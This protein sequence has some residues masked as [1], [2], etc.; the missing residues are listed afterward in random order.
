M[1]SVLYWS[2]P[3]VT[4]RVF[5]L[6]DVQTESI[7]GTLIWTNDG[8]RV[9]TKKHGWK[10]KQIGTIRTIVQIKELDSDKLVATYKAGWGHKGTLK[11]QDENSPAFM[12][13]Y[14]EK[15]AKSYVWLNAEE[16]VLVRLYKTE[17]T[18]TA[19]V[20]LHVPFIEPDFELLTLAGCYLQIYYSLVS[21][22]GRVPDGTR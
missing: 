22:G 9:R 1:I 14:T 16:K 5:E 6:R 3:F 10:F 4:K 17:L 21:K 12:W 18:R 19:R 7:E 11:F 2:Q 15:P 13:D 20:V 8:T